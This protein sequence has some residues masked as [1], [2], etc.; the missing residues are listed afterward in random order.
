MPGD[1]SLALGF[2]KREGPVLPNKLASELN[3][4][5]LFASA[6]LSEL[7]SKKEVLITSVKRGS[8][9][10]YYAKGQEEKLQELSQFLSGKPKEAYEL[11][12]EK[13]VLRE[14]IIEP[15]QRVA[16]REIKDFAVQLNVGL[17]E[18][19]EI[20][21]KWYLLSNDDAKDYIKE[22]VSG[23]KRPEKGPTAKKEKVKQE[24][25]S[26]EF[27]PEEK[28]QVLTQ[29]GGSFVEVKKF[30]EENQFYV[31][32]QEVVRKNKEANFVIDV[33]SGLGKLRYFV[34]LKNKKNI[35]D[36]D[37]ISAL[38]DANKKNLPVIFL[39]GGELNKKAEKYLNENISGKLVFKNI[40]L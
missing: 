24:S 4:N 13:K 10:F 36:Q 22:I 6:I 14:S 5:I 37:I 29:T 21:W 9:P 11:I 40:K 7:V 18:G 16:L 28:E 31:I 15:W 20:F 27:K 30:F 32:S 39:T 1:L 8:S 23:K 38:D 2:V 35:T 19:Y 12:K 3:T 33:P 17:K 34:K 26:S 25:E